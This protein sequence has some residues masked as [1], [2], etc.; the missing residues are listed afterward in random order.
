MGLV[1]SVTVFGDGLLFNSWPFYSVTEMTIWFGLM[2]AF[3][4]GPAI[5]G[6]TAG[7]ITAGR[8]PLPPSTVGAR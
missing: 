3:T 8:R 1:T 5:L 6:A 2:I 7:A 4:L